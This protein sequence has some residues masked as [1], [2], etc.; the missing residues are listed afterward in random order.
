MERSR[1]W[2]HPSFEEP[3]LSIRTEDEVLTALPWE[4]R[5]TQRQRQRQDDIQFM[6]YEL[7]SPEDSEHQPPPEA[8]GRTDIDPRLYGDQ[9]AGYQGAN[10][11]IID[12]EFERIPRS[13]SLNEEVLHDERYEGSFPAMDPPRRFGRHKLPSEDEPEE[14]EFEL[15]DEEEE[16][17]E[18]RSA[19]SDKEQ[20]QS[21]GSS[22]DRRRRGVIEEID[23]DEFFLREGG[24]SQGDTI[25]G[26]YL[27]NE[28]RDALRAQVIN[29]LADDSMM[30][31]PMRPERTRSFRKRKEGSV[32]SY[33][34]ITPVR[35]KRGDRARRSESADNYRERTRSDSRHRVVYQAEGSPREMSPVEPLDD[36]V[37]VKPIRR[38]SKSSQRSQSVQSLD[39]PPVVPT[40]R[41]RARN[42]N[43]NQRATPD[44]EENHTPICNGHAGD[45]TDNLRSQKYVTLTEQSQDKAFTDREMAPPASQ[46]VARLRDEEPIRGEVPIPPKRRSRSRGTSVAQDEDRTSH[47]AE[48]L[49]EVGYAE[50]DIPRDEL[51]FGLSAGYA[52]IDK[53]EKPPRPP[54]P[55]RRRDKFATTPRPVVPKRPQ[56]AYSTLASPARSRAAARSPDEVRH[57]DRRYIEFDSDDGDLNRDLR[58]GEILNKMQGRPLPAP[59]RP[60]RLRRGEGTVESFDQEYTTESTIATQTD[61]LPDDM[62]IEE[63]ITQAK[64]VVAP[65]TSGS[66]ILVSTER[67][68]SPLSTVP[69]PL[70]G[71]ISQR[72]R[73]MEEDPSYDTVSLKSPSP[74]REH[75]NL[76]D[77][78]LSAPHLD[79]PIPLRDYQAEIRAA[80]ASDEPLRI[81]NLEVADLRVDRLSVSQL[82]A[83]KIVTSEVDALVITASELKNLSESLQETGLSPSIVRE[84]IA[85]RSHLERV[86]AS[87][88]QIEEETRRPAEPE[89]SE[90]TV[91][92]ISGDDQ[93]TTRTTEEKPDQQKVVKR[94]VEKDKQDL[95]ATRTLSVLEVDVK[96]KVTHTLSV[97]KV[98]KFDKATHSPSGDGVDSTTDEKSLQILDTGSPFSLSPNGDQSLR[99]ERTELAAMAEDSTDNLE[100]T[101]DNETKLSRRSRSRSSSPSQGIGVCRVRQTASPVRSLPPAISVT[102]DTPDAATTGHGVINEIQPQRAIISYSSST[103]SET[104]SQRPPNS[105]FPL[106][107][108]THFIAFPASQFPAELLSL[109]QGGPSII[110]LHQIQTQTQSLSDATRQFLRALRLAGI[111]AIRHC[112]GYLASRTGEQDS[113]EKIRE[114]ELM[115]CALLLLI[116]GLLIFFFSST[117]TVT[118]HHHWDYFNPPQ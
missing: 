49:P 42:Q 102:P 17:Y 109:T 10:D 38:K 72:L 117:R 22:C 14:E 104:S 23:S 94:E 15:E 114:I 76:E 108:T 112:V 16:E 24:L 106:S 43:K 63:E 2:R 83:S 91:P 92:D 88:S 113:R 79:E 89:A 107:G 48:S 47:G 64:L 27:T 61:P 67:I 65:S 86:A 75:D 52:I 71:G 80:L 7:E 41:K 105:S 84:L 58:S 51:E 54:P 32:D 77:R 98:E 116:A 30:V 45:W 74:I 101:S 62:I 40:R 103:S 66:Q 44:E 20:Q 36:I 3:R 100:S 95:P 73:R 85:I 8:H 19:P 4:A 53:R 46:V 90:R 6:D 29:A 9:D 33:E 34:V 99:A 25:L 28:I 81:A 50:D 35:P 70:R 31:A 115:L 60:P 1:P 97:C 118:H 110:D 26:S 56:R 18:E 11:E 39:P 82:E 87:S 59:P 96:D 37:V 68:P 21:S 55:R 5:Q 111:K 57:P 93:E 78:H 69:P 13:R 12:D